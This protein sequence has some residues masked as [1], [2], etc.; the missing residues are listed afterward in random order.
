MNGHSKRNE[1]AG[2]PDR[3]RENFS[4]KLAEIVRSERKLLGLTQES[5]ALHA[6]VGRRFVSE[7]ETGK[8][9]LHLSKLLMVLDVLGLK[10]GIDKSKGSEA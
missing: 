4:A 3:E 6:G 8:P 9:S 1:K 2:D 5:L 10:L 7:L